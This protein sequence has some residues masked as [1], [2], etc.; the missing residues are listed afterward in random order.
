MNDITTRGLSTRRPSPPKGGRGVF[1][2]GGRGVQQLSALLLIIFGILL[3]F[4]ALFMPPKGE[5]DESVIYIFA[6]VLIYAGSVYGMDSY[7]A[8]CIEQRGT[9]PRD[10]TREE[11][12]P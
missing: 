2:K 7:I 9:H 12:Q 5:I 6:Q 10:S 1:L 3:A 8:H 11:V 4:V